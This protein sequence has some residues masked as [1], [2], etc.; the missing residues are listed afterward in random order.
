MA[1]AK[2][3]SYFEF[4]SKKSNCEHPIQIKN[5]KILTKDDCQHFL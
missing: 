2:Y 1:I 3:L 5:E 4:I